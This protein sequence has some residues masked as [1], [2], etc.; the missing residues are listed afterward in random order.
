MSVEETDSEFEDDEGDNDDDDDDDGGGGDGGGSDDGELDGNEE[1]DEDDE[2][3]D[4]ELPNREQQH[5]NQVQEEIG[6]PLQRR[7]SRNLDAR[8]PDYWDNAGVD[9]GDEPT[10]DF[11]ANLVCNCVHSWVEPILDALDDECEG[12]QVECH[13]CWRVDGEKVTCLECR[14]CGIVVCSECS[15]KC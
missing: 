13:R 6:H 14:H 9:F 12:I 3:E 7:R 1:S 11:R 2:N 8:P 4:D 15:Q 5:R 10:D